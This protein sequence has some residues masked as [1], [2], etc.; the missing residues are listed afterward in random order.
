MKIT[1]GT[2]HASIL[3]GDVFQARQLSTQELSVPHPC[4]KH[5]LSYHSS[6]RTQQ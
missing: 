4:H 6:Q 5:L 2:K 3:E 1:V